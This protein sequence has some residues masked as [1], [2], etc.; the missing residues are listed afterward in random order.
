MMSTLKLNAVNLHKRIDTK[1]GI[2]TII[3]GLNLKVENNQ[4]VA[5]VGQSGC[6]KSTLLSLLAGLDLPQQ[7]QIQI[8]GQEITDLTEDQ[9]AQ[10]RA[11]KTG[12]VFQ[13]FYL[14]DDLTALENI[15]LP[16]ELFG[17]KTPDKTAKIWLDKLGLLHRA[18]HYP[19]QL[20]G[21]EQQRVALGRAFAMQPEIL[22]ADEPTANLD[23]STANEVIEHLFTLHKNSNNSM[24]IVTHDHKLAQNCDKVY[25]LKNGK[26]YDS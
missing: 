7:G 8:N 14:M 9:R 4:S 5:I 6:G 10:F 17:H 15:A 22:F 16:L 11:N 2:I 3:D 21:G 12:F 20:S 13:S 24:I 18:N 25:F 26:L 1:A 23:V 19:K